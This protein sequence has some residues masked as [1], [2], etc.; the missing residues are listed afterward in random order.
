MRVLT[1]SAVLQGG[2]IE[3]QPGFVTEGEPSHEKGELTVE[4]LG[5][6][7]RPLATTM[8]PLQTPCGYPGGETALVAVGMVAFPEKATGLR[9]SLD[10][11]V[12]LEQ[13]ASQDNLEV[14]VEWP[15]SLS[16]VETLRWRASADACVA[17]LGYSNDGGETWTPLS[18]PDS[19]DMIKV[20]GGALPGGRKCFFELIVTDGFHSQRF[21]SDAYEVEP[22]GWVLWILS[23]AA[24][25]KLP[26]DQPVLLAAQGYH[27]E[28]RR[29][30]F[31]DIKWEASAGGGLGRGA[32]VLAVL[33][34]GEQIITASMYGVTA[35]VAV[36][37]V[38]QSGNLSA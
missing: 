3:L 33:D 14:N 4:A 12:L 8:L 16:G 23:P 17:V 18:L 10:G 6:G 2:K 25:A 20:D 26:A 35:H 37:V 24:G 36:S 31:D 30:S 28:E 15:T 7:Q 38:R 11:R 29:A 27:I 1:F 13:T 34:P 5:I 22:K 9:V 21:R 19:G 32:Q